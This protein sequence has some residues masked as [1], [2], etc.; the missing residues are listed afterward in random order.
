[1]Y[2]D[3]AYAD[4]LAELTFEARAWWCIAMA[5]LLLLFIFIVR[6]GRRWPLQDRYDSRSAQRETLLKRLHQGESATA[7]MEYL[8]VLFPFLI[9]VMTVWQLAFMINAQMHVAYAAYAAAR[10]ASVVIPTDLQNEKEGVLKKQGDAGATK[11]TRIRNAAIPG[12]LAISPGDFGTAGLVAAASAVRRGGAGSLLQPPDISAMVG[13]FTLMTVHHTNPGIFSGTRL[14][15]GVVK[16]AYAERMTQVLV[17]KQDHTK[18]QDMAGA[19]RIEVTVNYIFWLHVPYVGRLME[20][21]FEGYKNPIT[22]E[23]I[24]L[25]PYP[26]MQLSE[27]ISMTSWPRRRAIEPCT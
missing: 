19:D 2:I 7:S 23:Y 26:S 4:R 13:R 5:S 25:N 8:L 21:M 14:Q 27:T 15:R 18:A 10:S 24:L 12:T 11:W 16:N 9:I 6:A 17:N 22:G 1:M 20:A 3:I